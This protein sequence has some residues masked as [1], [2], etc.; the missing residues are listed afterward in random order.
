MWRRKR[1][2]RKRPKDRYQ[3]GARQ[4]NNAGGNKSTNNNEHNTISKR[5]YKKQFDNLV[6]CVHKK[7]PLQATGTGRNG[8]HNDDAFIRHND[9]AFIYG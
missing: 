9:D 1:D 3:N 8:R 5:I 7:R 6:K 2:H 4:D